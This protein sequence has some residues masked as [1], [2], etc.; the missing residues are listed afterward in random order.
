MIKDVSKSPSRT[1]KQLVEKHQTHDIKTDKVVFQTQ[2][3]ITCFIPYIEKYNAVN[4]V[5]IIISNKSNIP[6]TCYVKTLG[7]LL[8][9]MI[10][11]L[12]EIIVNRMFSY[13]IITIEVH[14]IEK[15]DNLLISFLI[16]QNKTEKSDNKR[17]YNLKKKLDLCKEIVSVIGGNLSLTQVNSLVN[18]VSLVLAK[19]NKK[20][21]EVKED[22]EML[23]TSNDLEVV[24]ILKSHYS[25]VL[26]FIAENYSNQNFKSTQIA[27]LMNM[28]LRTLQRKL[29]GEV[30]IT[31]NTIL[32]NYRI[33][34][35]KK[36]L[37][38][39]SSISNVSIDCGFSS[40]SHFTKK[41]KQV[42]GITAKEFINLKK[43]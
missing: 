13:E 12:I 7:K 32:Y 20:S 38:S 4:E 14:I 39:E 15:P 26:A 8:N 19:T 5:N 25:R 42:T 10:K 34:A 33:H 17:F 37:L 29:K 2:N 16:Y 30:I 24:P 41:F 18:R 1:K 22:C 31:L 23:Y 9:V 43:G 3:F 28:S 36:Q 35:A 27:S 21:K 6:K 40:Q 11:E